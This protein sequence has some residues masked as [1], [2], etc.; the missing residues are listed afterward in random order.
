MMRT[1]LIG[2]GKWG[3]TVAAKAQTCTD[4][5]IVA[6][7]DTDR[8]QAI[9]AA[10]ELGALYTH[11]LG[12]V[13]HP[14]VRADAAIIATPPAHR[15]D[16]IR[17]CIAAGIRVIRCEK[18]LAESMQD[19]QTIV[20][21]CEEHGVQLTV[22]FTLLH[23]PLYE[24][25]LRAAQALGVIEYVGGMRIGPP[26]RHG[27]DPLLDLA[28]HTTAVA[29]YVGATPR[30]II[31]GYDGAGASARTTVLQLEDGR[32]LSI[33]ENAGVVHTPLGT[34]TTPQHRDALAHELAAWITG[35]HRG[36][37]QIALT[38]QQY[39][40]DVMMADQETHIA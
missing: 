35:Q 36:T 40:I 27:A 31:A 37:P 39:I 30:G 7:I 25:A 14:S 18:P 10:V 11:Q 9:R 38:A 33:D 3:R 13:A 6:V 29:A 8:A 32:K 1:V 24:I 16:A 15:V 4:A 19:A 26:S 2:A 28:V 17:H 22:G 12:E 23:D 20:A 5:D 21:L 34:I